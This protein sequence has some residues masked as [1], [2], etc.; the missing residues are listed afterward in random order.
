VRHHLS[1][2]NKHILTYFPTLP[3]IH[4]KRNI[5]GNFILDF[6]S[7][8]EH[9]IVVK[10]S[11]LNIEDQQLLLLILQ[12]LLPDRPYESIEELDPEIEVYESLYID[13]HS[14]QWL[15]TDS[16]ELV[17]Q[18]I[19]QPVTLRLKV[20]KKR[21]EVADLVF[22]LFVTSEQLGAEEDNS[23]YKDNIGYCL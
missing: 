13:G 20:F 23:L 16:I 22:R 7:P 17:K 1:N 19:N 3:A 5:L 8:H 11:H 18:L 9:Q 2:T 10:P 4:L 14:F 21:L 12:T 15:D 6:C